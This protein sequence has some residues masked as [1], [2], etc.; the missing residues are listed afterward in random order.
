M[1]ERFPVQ[2]LSVPGVTRGTRPLPLTVRR[3]ALSLFAW[4]VSI[5]TMH[6]I[7]LN[8]LGLPEGVSSLS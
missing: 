4:T 6:G 5:L 8:H 2:Q 7:T 3:E 1:R